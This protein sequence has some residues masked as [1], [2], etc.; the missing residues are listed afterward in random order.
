MLHRSS[1]ANALFGELSQ[2]TCYGANLGGR[3]C[4]S[5]R[6]LTL[7]QLLILATC[8]ALALSGCGG[9]A[10]TGTSAQAGSLSASPG[11]VPFG[12]VALG[13]TANANVSVVNKGSTAVKLTRV[14]VTGQAFSV[15]GVDDL[16]ITVGAGSTYSLNVGFTP[17]ATGTAAGQLTIASNATNNG[18]MVI[19]L[20]GAG[21][22]A[23]SAVTLTG[24]S[25][26]SS[27]IAGSGTDNCT[28]TLS[29]A[30]QNSGLVVNVASNNAA[31]TAPATVTVA[32]GATSASFLATAAAVSSSQTATLTASAGSVTETFA[33]QLSANVQA[34]S[35]VTALT[36]LSCASGL[37][38]GA[39]NDNCTVTLNAPAPSGG[40]TVSLASNNLAATLPATVIVPA[41]AANASVTVAVSTVSTAQAVTLMATAGAVSE[42]YVLQLGTSTP[43]LSVDATSLAFGEVHVNTPSTQSISIVST[44]AQAVTVSSAVITGAGFSVS[45]NAFPV[46]LSTGQ[47]ITLNVQFDPTVG[48]SAAGTLTIVSTSLSNPISIINLSGTGETVTYEVDLS[49]G[50]PAS[51]ADPI[52]GYNIYRS[53]IGAFSYVQLNSSAITQTSYVDATVQYGKTYNYIVEGVDNA[54]VEGSPSNSATAII[55]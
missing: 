13:Q 1:V 50:P 5:T 44:G 31:V 12:S 15:S 41:G 17:Q 30:P 20:N 22:S 37:M 33:L 16:P 7:L 27:S 2:P 51:S 29:A 39:G 26:T 9:T 10:F 19:G 18:T 38:I 3:T 55:P 6:R 36:G 52:V 40:V 47:A 48:G 32:A 25:C 43:S 54:G 42:T 49:W 35:D 11:I 28:V 23:S 53:P 21:V 46:S 14:S 45:D 4:R 34:G 24:L 8:A